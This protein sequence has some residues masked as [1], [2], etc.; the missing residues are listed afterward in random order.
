[1]EKTTKNPI[2]KPKPKLKRKSKLKTGKTKNTEKELSYIEHLE[3]LRRRII[4]SLAVILVFSV[5]SYCKID[6]VLAF[7]IKPVGKLVFIKPAEAFFSRIKFS[8]WIG[9]FLSFP[10]IL[11]Q[12]WRFV[13]PALLSREK[14]FALKL[15]PFSYILF[16][17]G[18]LFCFFIV[19]PFAAK[20][21]LSFQTDNIQSMLS[22]ESYLSLVINFSLAFGLI[23]QMP[24]VIAVLVK[25]NIVTV[26]MLR[27]YR[28][29]SILG[30]FIV[31]A[32]ITPPDIVSQMMMA[33]PLLIIYE[34]SIFFAR[35]IK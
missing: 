17:V 20:Y 6:T 15:V 24:I 27:K 12:I 9:V 29:Y 18:V 31:A 13:S 19:I 2:K 5:V 28:K 32:I 30:I 16:T 22:M 26:E 34:I 8:F 23:F 33:I 11:F 25:L 35:F 7:V 4:F 3:E 1:L 21:F 10:V 14:K